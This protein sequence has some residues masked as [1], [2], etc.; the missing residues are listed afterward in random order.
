MTRLTRL[1]PTA[2]ALLVGIFIGDRFLGD[3]REPLPPLELNGSPAPSAPVRPGSA[4]AGAG[5]NRDGESDTEALTVL[6]QRL[7]EESSRREALAERVDALA[8]ALEA[9]EGRLGRGIGPDIDADA[10]AEAAM[11]QTIEE[12][13]SGPALSPEERELQRYIDAGF[14][15]VRAEALKARQDDLALQRL[16]LRDQARRE[17]WMGTPR[18]REELGQL[19]AQVQQLRTEL[20]DE[21]Y[22]R[23]LYATGRPNRVVVRTTLT[24][25]P[26]AEAGLRPGDAI[27]SYDG[28]RVFDT[29]T[30]MQRTQEGDFGAPT[31]VEVERD[32]QRLLLYV[33]RGP[34]GVN[35]RSSMRNPE[36]G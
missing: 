2:L 35:M 32:G 27:L 19:N 6:R 20:G 17:G 12:M 36:A 14:S 4:A 7:A 10:L 5:S 1:L 30:L 24:G 21:D 18:Y 9:I 29:R 23:F 26:A 25:G 16:F 33:P 34:L 3:P 8:Q 31:P 11:E 13:V 22:D 15:P 28:A